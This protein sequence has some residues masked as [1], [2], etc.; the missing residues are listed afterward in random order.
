MPNPEYVRRIVAQKP[1]GWTYRDPSEIFSFS[2]EELDLF[3][4]H[5][6]V[7][8]YWKCAIY[9]GVFYVV[10]IFGLQ[11]WMRDRP[12]MDLKRPLFYWNFVLGIFS[13]AGFIRM[14]PGFTKNLLEPNGFYDSI[15]VKKGLDI[16]TAF[17]TVLFIL[18]KYLELGDTVFI[19]FIFFKFFQHVFG[20]NVKI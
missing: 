20:M 18:S 2:F 5:N 19:G 15:C 11:R 6:F 12:A 17:W 13:I 4:W 14:L 16:P 9:A 7:G 10:T 1:F 3:W 8:E